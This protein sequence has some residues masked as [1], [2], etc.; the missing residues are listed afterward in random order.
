MSL[1]LEA[2]ERVDPATGLALDDEIE[3]LTSQR[4]KLSQTLKAIEANLRKMEGIE[5]ELFRRIVVDGMKRS[6]AVREVAERSY[7]SEQ[8]VWRYYYPKIKEEL[9]RLWQK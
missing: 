7:L 9:E 4:R 5:F 1:Y 6:E 3:L 2:M 8:T